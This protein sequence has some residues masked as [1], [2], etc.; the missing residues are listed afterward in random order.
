MSDK[1]ADLF[2]AITPDPWRKVKPFSTDIQAAHVDLFDPR[3]TREDL[4][5]TLSAWLK[6]WQPCLFGRMAAKTQIAYCILREGDLLKGEDHVRDI[7]QLSRREWRRK[8]FLGE[9]HGFVIALISPMVASAVPD[10]ALCEL[11]VRLCQLYLSDELTTDQIF[12]D[13]L[14]LSIDRPDFHE[15]RIWRAGVNFF[16][17]QGDQR[18]WHDHRIPGGIAF[19]MNSVGHMTRARLE[20]QVTKR[21]ALAAVEPAER[22]VD[23]AL[24]FA[25]RTVHRA[26]KGALPGTRLAER[27]ASC[28]LPEAIREVALRDMAPFNERFYLGQYHTDMTIPGEYFDPS[29]VKPL[30]L[31]ELALDFTYLHDTSEADYGLMGVG[32]ASLESEVLS[33]LGWDEMEYYG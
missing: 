33:A 7:I 4:A 24:A 32:Q 3:K 14:P 27:D 6:E 15:C 11:A 29:I 19:S 25:M 28:I 26:S 5:V 22:L 23:F 8:G 30:H 12:L 31:Q 10:R 21:P 18:W 9:K 13:S 20:A 2:D 16:G 17:A 1:L